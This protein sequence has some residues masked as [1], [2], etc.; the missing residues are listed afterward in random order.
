MWWKTRVGVLLLA[1]ASLGAS[2]PGY[3]QNLDSQ[4]WKAGVASSV[5]LIYA[6]N[7]FGADSAGVEVGYG[8]DVLIYRGQFRWEGRQAVLGTPGALSVDVH[9]QAAYSHW[10]SMEDDAQDGANDINNSLSF[11]PVF[12]VNLPWRWTP[13]F[14]E[15]WV[16]LT[17]VSTTEFAGRNLGVH[18]QFEDV[19]AVGWRLGPRQRW[20][21]ALRQLHYS[22]NDIS[23]END[24][25]TLH[26][27]GLS[28]RY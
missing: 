16:G 27:I 21:L 23:S 24:G 22:N 25:V 5:A 8:D 9:W 3:A 17:A 2:A 1:V 13:D 28:Y 26:F 19:L 14:I 18:F 20:E 7:L 6:S 4:L 12:R 15:A 10:R 11:A